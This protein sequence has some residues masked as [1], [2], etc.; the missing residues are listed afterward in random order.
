MDVT[1]GRVPYVGLTGDNPRSIRAQMIGYGIIDTAVYTN[2]IGLVNVC[3]NKF[4]PMSLSSYSWRK[5]RRYVSPDSLGKSLI[6]LR[7][8]DVG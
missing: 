1:R 3:L 5:K 8:V 6:F 7:G 4:Q 2:K